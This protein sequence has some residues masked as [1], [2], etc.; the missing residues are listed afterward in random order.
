M[1]K[2]NVLIILFVISLFLFSCTKNS[3]NSQS[4]E[5]LTTKSETEDTSNQIV[6][7]TRSFT[8]K[9]FDDTPE[10]KFIINGYSD[11]D[12]ACHANKIEIFDAINNQKLQE[13]NFDDT[14][15]FL[16]YN[17]TLGFRLTDLNFD[18][19]KDIMF[20]YA[21]V[22][23]RANHLYYCWLWDKDSQ[24]FVENKS[25]SDIFNPAIDRKNKQLLSIVANNAR[26]H[27]WGMYIFADGKFLLSNELTE[28][29]LY[30]EIN[31]NKPKWHYT[32]SKLENGTMNVIEDF[33]IIDNSNIQ[34]EQYHDENSFWGLGSKK[35]YM[36]DYGSGLND[37][38]TSND[39]GFKFDE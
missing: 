31:T 3:K 23:A 15:I 20:L 34:A 9:V 4:N 21:S 12:Y 1:K 10:F 7:Y 32:E 39:L 11:N 14:D 30:D 28:E 33:T 17:N 22:S 5:S 2:A 29:L 26:S 6:K 8:G 24:R 27:T 38:K 19:Y 25:F 16:S 13:M 36:S 35:W 37:K 18:G